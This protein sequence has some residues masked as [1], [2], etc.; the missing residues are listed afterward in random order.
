MRT[1]AE[2]G[3]N[4]HAAGTL[5]ITVGNGFKT[6]LSSG[7]LRNVNHAVGFNRP[8]SPEVRRLVPAVLGTHKP[9]RAIED[10]L[11]RHLGERLRPVV[12]PR[13][14]VEL[15]LH[16][17]RRGLGGMTCLLLDLCLHG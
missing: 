13:V 15:V 11:G 9:E 4:T 7:K 8:T 10:Q 6:F 12:E 1:S 3:A 14:L 2:G 5:N 16:L 17:I